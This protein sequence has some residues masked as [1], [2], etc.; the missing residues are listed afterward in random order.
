MATSSAQ[1]CV[2]LISTIICPCSPGFGTLRS[3]LQTFPRSALAP[4][5]ALAAHDSTPPRHSDVKKK[6]RGSHQSVWQGQV[7][8]HSTWLRVVRGR[9]TAPG[10]IPPRPRLQES[11]A[12]ITA[13]F[14]L[15]PLSII[16]HLILEKSTGDCPPP[17]IPLLCAPPKPE[18]ECPLLS[19]YNVSQNS[20]QSGNFKERKTNLKSAQTLYI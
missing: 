5:Q 20:V 18:S 3:V 14:T 9:L 8:Q 12:C 7:W 15:L 4:D 10:D 17:T 16:Q 13:A 6:Q 11:H 19:S 1:L 2:P